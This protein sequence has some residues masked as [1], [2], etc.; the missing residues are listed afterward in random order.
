MIALILGG[1]ALILGGEKASSGITCL[2]TFGG[3][4]LVGFVVA[5]CG[6]VASRQ[7]LL[8]LSPW[9]GT[10]NPIVARIVC[11]IVL[12]FFVGLA[13]IVILVAVSAR[14]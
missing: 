1:L 14:R 12:L 7:R 6:V 2:V 11:W 9:I 5:L 4:T 13:V 3:M 10:K 8:A